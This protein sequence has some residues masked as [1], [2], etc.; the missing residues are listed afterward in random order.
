MFAPLTV[1]SYV[2][3]NTGT[4]TLLPCRLT[5]SLADSFS[6]RNGHPFAK[7]GLKP[8]DLPHL[9]VTSSCVRTSKVFIIEF[10]K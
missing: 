6:A 10:L 5:W 3:G 4:H 2:T 1:A 9:S 7:G 8:S